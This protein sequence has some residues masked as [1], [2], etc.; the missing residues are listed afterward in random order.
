MFLILLILK[1]PVK[2]KLSKYLYFNFLKKSLKAQSRKE[3]LQ[4]IGNNK[5]P[6][7]T[8]LFFL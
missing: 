4:Q 7:P 3:A 2:L 6:I 1:N 5:F 8:S